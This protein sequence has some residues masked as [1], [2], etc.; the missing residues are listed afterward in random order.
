METETTNSRSTPASPEDIPS[1]NSSMPQRSLVYSMLLQ[2]KEALLGSASPETA[3][4]LRL[5][6]TAIAPILTRFICEAATILLNYLQ[7]WLTKWLH[8]A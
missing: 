5:A 6:Y 7:M 4:L 1:S 8:P 3:A 2:M